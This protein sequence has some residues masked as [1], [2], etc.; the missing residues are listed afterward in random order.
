[1]FDFGDEFLQRKAEC[2]KGCFTAQLSN[3]SFEEVCHPSVPSQKRRNGKKMEKENKDIVDDAQEEEAERPGAP[4]AGGHSRGSVAG[5]P[6]L[7]GRPES[8][9]TAG[10]THC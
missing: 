9:G 2:E 8:E 1:M 3:F 6:R 5:E 4:H 7:H 10:I